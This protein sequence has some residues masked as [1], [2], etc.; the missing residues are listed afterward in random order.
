[1]MATVS[2]KRTGARDIKKLKIRN[3]KRTES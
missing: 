1:M 2:H 3:Q